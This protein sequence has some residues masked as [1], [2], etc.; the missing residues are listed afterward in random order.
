MGRK[1]ILLLLAAALSCAGC[2]GDSSA[3]PVQSDPGQLDCDEPQLVVEAEPWVRELSSVQRFAVRIDPETPAVVE[4]DA[5]SAEDEVLATLTEEQLYG[6]ESYA[7]G[8]MRVTL[9]GPFDPVTIHSQGRELTA[10]YEV[11]SVL[12]SQDQQV[13]VDAVFERQP[14]GVETEGSGPE[15]AGAIDVTDSAI[16]LPSCGL[17]YRTEAKAGLKPTLKSLRYRSESS[18]ASPSMV[19]ANGV[20]FTSVKA[21]DDAAPADSD[22]VTSWLDTNASGLVGSTG[23][24]LLSI[25]HNSLAWREAASTMATQCYDPATPQPQALTHCQALED[26]GRYRT[27]RQTQCGN[28]GGRDIPGWATGGELPGAPKP[29]ITCGLN[30]C[31]TSWGD[32][33]LTTFDGHSYDFQ[34]AGEYVLVETRREQENWRVQARFEPWTGGSFEACANVSI[35]TAVATNVGDV[36]LEFRPDGVMLVNGVEASPADVTAALPADTNFAFE[37]GSTFSIERAD[38]TVMHVKTSGAFDVDIEIPPSLSGLVTGLMGNFDGTT[39]NDFQSRFGQT[40]DLSLSF[41][42][43]YRTYG[44]SWRVRDSLFTYDEGQSTEDF[45]VEDFPAAATT[46]DDVPREILE[47]AAEKCAT[48]DTAMVKGCV[49]DEICLEEGAKDHRDKAPTN[50]NSPIDEPGLVLRGDIAQA[51]TMLDAARAQGNLCGSAGETKILLEGGEEA[52]IDEAIEGDR[53]EVPAGTDVRIWTLKLEHDA[54]E[55][56]RTGSVTFPQNILAVFSSDDA[57][58]LT[59]AGAAPGIEDEDTAEIEAPKTL[60]LDL[61]APDE[62]D[63]VRVLTEVS[64]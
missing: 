51:S 4:V 29:T 32:P 16:S 18:E 38:G 40:Y 41:E 22:A 52:T 63:T 28:G 31:S 14:C 7:D 34:G 15:C 30:G 20:Q 13:I 64:P 55:T 47:A 62:A 10:G 23:E 59:P 9:D 54:N 42:D 60:K 21:V 50:S 2:G 6:D 37:G 12:E 58:A 8:T 46:F 45:T 24:E 19:I 25:I 3:P 5:I 43:L 1:S 53:G 36:V 33:H 35:G 49:L 44:D 26:D 61:W 48:Q 39:A 11:V 27:L 17:P 56:R 57:L